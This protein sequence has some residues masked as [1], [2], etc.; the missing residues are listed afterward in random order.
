[1]PSTTAYKNYFKNE[2]GGFY[3]AYYFISGD[4]D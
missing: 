1:M 3:S 2:A 4:G